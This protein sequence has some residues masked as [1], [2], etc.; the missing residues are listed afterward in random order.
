MKSWVG[1]DTDE[2]ATIVAMQIVY[3][4]GFAFEMY[5]RAEIIKILADKIN[6][7]FNGFRR[8]FRI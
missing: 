8:R 5:S 7:F 2:R 6:W 3:R 4:R 1:V